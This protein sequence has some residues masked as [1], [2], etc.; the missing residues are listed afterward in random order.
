MPHAGGRC[1]ILKQDD[2]IKSYLVQMGWRFGQSY[3]GG[4]LAGQLVMHTIANR[5][6][7]GWGSWLRV[8]DTVP[9]YMAENTLPPLVHPSVWEPT[10]VKLLSVVEGIYDGSVADMTRGSEFPQAHRGQTGALYFCALNRIERPW[11]RNN[12][13]NA[14]NPVT[15]LSLHQRIADM[16][17][18]AFFD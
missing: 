16:N 4:H 5:V 9:E 6:H 18:L 1:Q 11:F 15:G 10:F 2:F 14:K 8:L 13:V 12:I 3:G 7:Q 17:T